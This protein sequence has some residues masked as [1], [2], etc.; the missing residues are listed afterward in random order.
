MKKINNNKYIIL[1]KSNK[2][3]KTLLNKKIKQKKVYFF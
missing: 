2:P 3:L 1:F